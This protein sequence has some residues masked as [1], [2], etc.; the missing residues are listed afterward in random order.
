MASMSVV[1]ARAAAQHCARVKQYLPSTANSCPKGAPAK[2][3]SWKG[4]CSTDGGTTSL[5]FFKSSQ[6]M[7]SRERQLSLEPGREVVPAA[8][9]CQRL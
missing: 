7:P 2:L 9:R 1:K 8:S 6:S 3:P 5:S 4:W